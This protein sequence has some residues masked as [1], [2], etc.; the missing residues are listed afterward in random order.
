MRARFLKEVAAAGLPHAG[1]S[2]RVSETLI[3]ALPEPAQRFMRFMGVPGR[4]RDWSFRAHWRGRFRMKPESWLPCEILQYNFAA[5]ITRIFHMRVR[6]AGVLPV[7]ARD[8]Y[9]AGRGSLR[10]KLLGLLTVAEESGDEID[11]G[12]LVTWLNDAVLLAPSMLMS[13]QVKTS[14]VDKSSFDVAVTDSGRTVSARVSVDDDG[15]LTEFSTTD[16][17]WKPPSDPNGP[18][19]R[20][21]WTTPVDGWQLVGHRQLPARGKAVWNADDGPYPYAE[22]VFAPDGIEYNVAP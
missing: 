6:I 8:M 4:S 15:R 1:D 3:Q 2:S 18:W 14:P 16:R 7:V 13:P 22:I 10:A 9:V 17:F 12:E 11:A 20:C 19:Q 5:P 21:R